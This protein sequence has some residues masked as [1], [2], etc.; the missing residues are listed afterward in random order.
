[1]L[2]IILDSLLP[3][4]FGMALGYLGGWTRDVD[5]K[6]VAELNALVMDSAVPASMFVT[7]VQASRRTLLDELPLAAN[8]SISMLI[9]YLVTYVM[10]RRAFGAGPGEASIQALTTSLPNYASAGLPLISAL[11]G[12]DHL[13]AA[14]VAIACG[15]IVVSPITLVIL[16]RTSPDKKGI[17]TSL[18]SAVMKP[19][20][21]SPILAVAFVLTGI[22]LPDP[23]TKSFSLMGQ[24]A[25][26]AGLF[27]TGLI[28]SAQ[29]VDLGANTSI[30]TLLSNVAHPLL[31]AALAWLFALPPLTAREAIVL[32]A[33]PVGFF[34]VLFGLR[35]NKS[36]EVAG[37]TL[38]ASTLLSAATLSAAIYLTTDL[39]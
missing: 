3:V 19:I 12:A 30:Q 32:S 36:S 7:V 29:K 38:I 22:G 27:L 18:V 15:S 9:L 31:A 28:L 37:T 39:G 4:F 17:T 13:V 1:M 26:G 16:D 14:A 24:V 35:F 2:V 8:L 34:G 25:G 6:H 5:N 10:A 11:L 21:L 20:V 23:L 33:L